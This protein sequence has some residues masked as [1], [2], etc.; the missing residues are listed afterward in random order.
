MYQTICIKKN[1]YKLT[2]DL[3]GNTLTRHYADITTYTATYDEATGT[4]IKGEKI[5]TIQEGRDTDFI[6]QYS[7]GSKSYANCVIAVNAKYADITLTSSAPGAQINAYSTKADALIYNGEKVAS[8]NASVGFG[9]MLFYLTP[10]AGCTFTVNAENITAYCGTLFSAE[11]GSNGTE[12]ITVNNGTFYTVGEPEEGIFGVRNGEKV[13]VSEAT[14]YGNGALLIKNTGSNRNKKT[15]FNFDNCKIYNV[16]INSVW[17]NDVYTF[18]NSEIV[19]AKKHSS[20]ASVVLGDNTFIT[21]NERI[22][23][24]QG[25][26]LVSGAEKSYS[27][28]AVTAFG[29]EYDTLTGK[30]SNAFTYET[31]TGTFAYATADITEYEDII[32]DDARLS[33]IFTSNF[34]LMFYLPADSAYTSVWNLTKQSGTVFIEGKEYYLYKKARKTTTATENVFASATFEKDGTVYTQTF[35]IDALVYAD[36]VLSDPKND[37]EAN[38]VANMLRYIKEACLTANVTI[39][40]ESK[41]TTLEALY[42]LGEYKDKTEYNDNG[43]DYSGL[44]KV[45][46]AL[47][48]YSSNATYI[49]NLAIADYANAANAKVTV[50]TSDGTTLTVAKAVEVKTNNK[51][52]S[53][54]FNVTTPIHIYDMLDDYVTISITIPAS[55]T[56]E[57]VELTGTYSIGAYIQATDN[58]LAKAVYEFGVAAK[59]YREYLETL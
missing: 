16:T 43:V 33:I 28:T 22:H 1:S 35:R 44:N 59:A 45:S 52:T 4:Y 56:T 20:S 8:E 37:I 46:M 6:V 26:L 10:A 36:I 51:V 42:P 19:L 29:C 49:I 21:H 11:H 27:H 12:K 47:G 58:N 17:E 9:L 53:Y 57:A 34:D 3:N 23:L 25:N 13:T 5:E 18:T 41:F 32:I 40:N 48:V 38:A 30:F 14:F 39:S 24:A 15:S 7:N 55:S 31:Q 54:N 50:E 2:L